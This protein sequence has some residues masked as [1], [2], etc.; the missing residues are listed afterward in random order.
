L[1]QRLSNSCRNTILY[2]FKLVM[3]EA[4]RAG[5]I[6]MLP[7]FESF[8]R[9]GKRQDVLSSE[10]LTTLFPYNE[11]KATVARRADTEE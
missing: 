10:G 2:T 9:N 7:E 6:E 8:R 4:K 11:L 3:R 5:I 1:E